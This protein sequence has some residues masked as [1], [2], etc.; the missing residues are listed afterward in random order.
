MIDTH[1]HLFSCKRPLNELVEN[2]KQ[3]GIQHI[4]N[5]GLNRETWKQAE[6]QAALY[7][8][9][10]VPTAG[11]Y[12]GQKKDP[13]FLEEIEALAKTNQI[14]AIGEIG[15]DYFRVTMPR[16]EQIDIFQDQLAIAART[17][18]PVIIHNRQ[19][20]D[21]IIDVCKQFP[22]VKKVFHCF[23]SGPKHI[24]QLMQASAYFSFTATILFSDTSEVIAGINHIPMDRIMIETDCPYLT[25]RILGKVENQP[26]HVGYVAEKIAAIKGLPVDLVKEVTTQNALQFFKGLRPA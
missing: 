11:L 20:D 24:D 3:A 18:Y 25:P 6:A 9:F 21:D 5:V 8:G 23:G 7:P 22:T 17:H 14:A 2:A 1:A 15:L 10:I 19:A 13:V 26:A 16:E 4:I 12:P